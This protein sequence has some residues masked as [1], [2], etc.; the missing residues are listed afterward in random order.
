[1]CYLT[2]HHARN[3]ENWAD[4]M[5]GIIVS[6]EKDQAG[7]IKG[8]GFPS[9]FMLHKDNPVARKTLVASLQIPLE[10]SRGR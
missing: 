3:A 5:T 8:K 9:K 1:M 2:I 7:Y 4:S 6:P 10:V